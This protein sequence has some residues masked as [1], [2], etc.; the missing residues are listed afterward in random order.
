[1]KLEDKDE[2][3]GELVDRKLSALAGKGTPL[4]C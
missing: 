1:M 3:R 2:D 4:S